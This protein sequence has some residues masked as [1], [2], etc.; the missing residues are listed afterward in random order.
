MRLV[1]LLFLSFLMHAPGAE[2][3]S[4]HTPVMP[5]SLPANLRLVA[6]AHESLASGIDFRFGGNDPYSGMDG[7]AYVGYL[8]ERTV[9]IRLPRTAAE[10]G[11]TGEAVP[12]ARMQPGDLVLFHEA[13]SGK[14]SRRVTHVGIYIG[15][16][17]FIHAS[18]KYGIIKRAS[19]TS[20][21]WKPRFHGARRVT[22]DSTVD[23]TAH[24]SHP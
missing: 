11:Q 4:F 7:S 20:A 23:A 19:L 13:R 12:R 9:G 17:E 24:S 18:H 21:Y 16:Q 22:G 8:V 15:N 1:L 6:H 2:V 14:R 3:L 10:I 5:S